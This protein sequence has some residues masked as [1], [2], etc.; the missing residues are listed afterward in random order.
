M[1]PFQR[2]VREVSINSPS[3]KEGLRWQSNALYSLQSAAEAYM[4]GF[5][6]DVN[7]CARHRKVIT[8]NRQDIWLAI[9]IRGREHVGGRPQVADVGSYN[10]SGF[11]IADAVEKKIVPKG[12]RTA[13]ALEPDWCAELRRN[14][15]VVGD[16]GSSRAASK[17]TPG[18]KRRRRVLQ[19]SIH[20]ISKA[21]FCRLARRGGVE[22]ISGN[23]FEESR[24]VLKVFLE[25]VIKDAI[26]ISRR[27]ISYALRDG[28][29]LPGSSRITHDGYFQPIRCE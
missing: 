6:H 4:A 10:V 25:E 20:A 14:V 15:A 29:K 2:L 5:F 19:N 22:R 23:V 3:A 27:K 7:L 12:A 13:F 9:T 21:A 24:G 16:G 17:N 18:M 26:I 8:I 11:T 1:L 28:P